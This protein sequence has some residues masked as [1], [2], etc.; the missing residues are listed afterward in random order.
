[1]Y[2]S[3]LESELTARCIC[4]NTGKAVTLAPEGHVPTPGE[5][6]SLLAVVG[7]RIADE[8]GT[9]VV[10]VPVGPDDFTIESAIG[11]VRDGGVGDNSRGCCHECRINK[12]PTS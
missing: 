12:R 7:V 9:N 4:L 6:C 1:M 2:T 5:I 8:G 11:I 10:G 3:F